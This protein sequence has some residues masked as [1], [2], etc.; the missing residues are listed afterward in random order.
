MKGSK[1]LDKYLDLARKLKKL[2]NVKVTF[3]P[4][5]VG[6]L[7]T[8]DKNLKKRLCE[9][10]MKRRIEILQT[11]TLLKSVTIL[12]RVLLIWRDMLSFSFPWKINRVNMKN[13]H[14]NED[15]S[16]QKRLPKRNHRQQIL[17]GDVSLPHRLGRRSTTRL[18]AGDCFPKYRKHAAVAQQE[19][20]IYKT[21]IRKSS[22]RA[23]RVGKM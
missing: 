22:R 18:Y 11:T 21:L 13:L 17:A 20:K 2:W 12:R 14:Y 4:V 15:Y 23:K 16:D 3:I 8:V 7:G 6:V 5:I 10:K 1:K 9:L 19:Q